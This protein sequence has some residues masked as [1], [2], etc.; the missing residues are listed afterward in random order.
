VAAIVT[1]IGGRF[2]VV[3]INSGGVLVLTAAIAD[4][5]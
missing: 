4:H 5:L 3:S 1:M 2:I